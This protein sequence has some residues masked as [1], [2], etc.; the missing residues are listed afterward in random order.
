MKSNLSFKQ[1]IE[2]FIVSKAK[3]YC[4][5]ESS[6]TFCTKHNLQKPVSFFFFWYV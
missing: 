4:T 6:R 1:T 3:R 2:L 5:N